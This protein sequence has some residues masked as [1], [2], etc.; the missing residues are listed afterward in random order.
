MADGE[1]GNTNF[2]AIAIHA[3]FNIHTYSRCAL[4]QNCKLRMMIK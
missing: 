4:I 2:P 3:A 1:E